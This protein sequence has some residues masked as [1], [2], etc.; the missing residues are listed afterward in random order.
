MGSEQARAH[1][2]PRTHSR[3]QAVATTYCGIQQAVAV[4]AHSVVTSP[5]RTR[6]LGHTRSKPPRLQVT[7]GRNGYG[8]KLANIFS[9][10]FTLETQAAASGKAYK[11]ASLNRARS[12][13]HTH[14][15]EAM[16]TSNAAVPVSE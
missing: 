13:P 1:K 5:R 9:T 14:P 3:R 16:C 15:R 6:V 11:Q 8:A 7:G 4:A 2:H 10:E 12:A